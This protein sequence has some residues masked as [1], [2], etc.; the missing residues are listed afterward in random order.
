MRLDLFFLS[1]GMIPM[2]MIPCSLVQNSFD[3]LNLETP[4]TDL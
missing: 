4:L 3:V 1:L 2:A